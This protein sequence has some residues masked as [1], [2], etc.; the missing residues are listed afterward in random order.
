[1]YNQPNFAGGGMM[2][3]NV[4]KET[5]NVTDLLPGVTYNFTVIAYND[6]GNST[7][8]ETTPLRTLDEGMH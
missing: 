1:M 4:S 7:E 3:L 5:V 8:S 2:V 6:I